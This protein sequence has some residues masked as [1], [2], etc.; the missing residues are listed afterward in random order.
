MAP[1]NLATLNPSRPNFFRPTGG[2]DRGMGAA[3]MKDPISYTFSFR[4]ITVDEDGG[5]TSP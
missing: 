4:F 1:M 5:V 3:P 2:D